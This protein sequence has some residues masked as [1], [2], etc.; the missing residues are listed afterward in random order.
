M[1]PME[2]FVDVCR[3]LMMMAYPGF[4]GLGEWEPVWVLLENKEEFD[5]T[6]HGS[7]DLSVESTV[8]WCVNKELQLGKKFSD[9]FGSNEKSKMIVKVT[10]RGGGAP[11]REPVIGESEHKQMLAYYHKKQEEAKKLD[12]GDDGDQYLNSAWADNR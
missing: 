10:K 3:G 4:H 11:Q 9:Y 1:A 2:E 8:L 5:S 6:L 7:D 12:D